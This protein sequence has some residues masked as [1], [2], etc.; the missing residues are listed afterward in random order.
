MCWELDA[1]DCAEEADQVAVLERTDGITTA[2]RSDRA[3]TRRHIPPR[4]P[5]DPGIVSQPA[6][7]VQPACTFAGYGLEFAIAGTWIGALQSRDP[8]GPQLCRD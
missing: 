6:S 3:P 2:S 5:H 1:V 8:C 4:K 7:P